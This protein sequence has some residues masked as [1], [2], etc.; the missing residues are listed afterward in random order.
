MPRSRAK[1]SAKPAAKRAARARTSPNTNASSNS[2]PT[3]DRDIASRLIAWFESSARPLPWR[4]DLVDSSQLRDPYACLVAEAMLQQTQVSRVVEYLARFLARFPTVRALAAADEADVLALW[5][6]L[7]YYRRARNLHAAARLI[8]DRFDGVVPQTPQELRLLP[9]VGPYTAGAIASIVFRQRAA[10]VDGNVQRVLQRLDAHAGE[11][12]PAADWAW[13]RAEV[14]ISA[15]APD[16]PAPETSLRY[17]R[18][19]EAL[20]ELGALVCLPPPAQPRCGVCPLASHCLAHQRGITDQIPPAKVT[21]ATAS[22]HCAV[23]VIADRQ[24]RITVEQRPPTGMWSNMWQAPTLEALGTKPIDRASIASFCTLRGG[25]SSTL[26][27]AGTFTHQTTHRTLHIQVFAAS[28]VAC[29]RKASTD[30]KRV[31]LAEL[32]T[33]GISTAARRAIEMAM[34][35]V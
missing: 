2:N 24:G 6:G 9:G 18:F 23:I 5:S 34:K 13:Q 10:L 1:P 29:S 17:A 12:K 3:R 35:I 8:V 7:G 20:M 32:D 28:P 16:E 33:L 4:T 21:K 25:D 26:R 14:L 22:I 11:G 27:P 31:T 30:R 15:A 19:N